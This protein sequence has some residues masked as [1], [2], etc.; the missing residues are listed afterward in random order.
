M[1]GNRVFETGS[2]F[3]SL[4]PTAATFILALQRRISRTNSTSSRVL[5]A[6]VFALECTEADSREAAVATKWME[7]FNFT[8]HADDK[9]CVGSDD[10]VLAS[11]AKHRRSTSDAELT[12]QVAAM[13]S[14]RKNWMNLLGATA[15]CVA[16]IASTGC[17]VDVAG[18]TLPSPYYQYDDIQIYPR[19]PEFK[20]QNEA[21]A[22]KAYKAEQQLGT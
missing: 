1:L 4:A 18:Q 9:Q 22:M 21:D 10:C 16:A 8:G 19:G 13:E 3:D 2:N 14:Q 17:Q 15:I 12:G 11:F 20:L 7:S 6:V 5:Q